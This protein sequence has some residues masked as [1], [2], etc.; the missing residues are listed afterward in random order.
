MKLKTVTLRG[1]KSIAKLEA[2]DLCELNVL[3]ST[4]SVTEY[5]NFADLESHQS[6]RRRGE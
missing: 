3:S 5:F 2:L 6:S 1:C 4:G